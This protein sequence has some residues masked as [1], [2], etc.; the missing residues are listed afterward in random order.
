MER[1]I[2]F[3]VYLAIKKKGP[4]YIESDFIPRIKT[5]LAYGLDFCLPVYKIDFYKYFYQL[6][7]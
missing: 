4:L 5:L 3:N 7:A 2:I 1:A 6:K